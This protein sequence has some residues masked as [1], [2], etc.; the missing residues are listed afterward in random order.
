MTQH[1]YWFVMGD[2][3]NLLAHPS[4]AISTVL[5]PTAFSDT[6]TTLLN[7]MQ[8]MN[9]N[10][11]I[12]R[13]EHRENDNTELVQRSFTL[14]FEALALTMFNF[15]TAISQKKHY[16]A[17]VA[18]FD[19]IVVALKNW[20]HAISGWCTGDIIECPKYCVSFHLPLHRHLSTAL[21]HFNDMELFR[22]HVEDFRKDEPLLRRIV[23]HPLKIQ[24]SFS[25]SLNVLVFESDVA[26]EFY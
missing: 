3:Q 20:I 21:S 26:R 2:I 25:A 13:G 24:V 18:F 8:G 4:L 10:W 6:Y 5:H 7:R 1:G 17:A 16:V 12:V 9:V 22:R 15:I 11:R 19:K 23:L 14:E